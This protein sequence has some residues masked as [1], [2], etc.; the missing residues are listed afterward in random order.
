M[1]AKLPK[2][3]CNQRREMLPFIPP[4]C[5]R[6]LEVGCGTGEFAWLVKKERNAEVWGIDIYKEIAEKAVN[7]LDKVLHG[8][9]EREDL[10]LPAGY[11]DCIVF[12]DVLEHL[13]DPWAVLRKA[14]LF[15]MSDGYIV[16]SIPNVRYFDNIKQL[17]KHK[18]WR[19]EDEGI[20]D[21]TH[22]RFFTMKSSK[23][24]FESCGY[25]VESITGITGRLFPWKFRMLNAIMKRTFDD[26]RYQRFACVA[27]KKSA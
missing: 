25:A 7:K 12:N 14:Q 17:L 2:Y 3:Y 8:D 26:M 18:E 20:L 1:A 22:L 15:L 16:A 23:E 19:Y 9:I 4:G 11:F 6:L 27:Q 13:H 24:L 10:D 21:R 5:K